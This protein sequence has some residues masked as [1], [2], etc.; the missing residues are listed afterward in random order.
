MKRWTCLAALLLVVSCK[1]EKNGSDYKVVVPKVETPSAPTERE[2]KTDAK[3][4]GDKIKKEAHEAAQSDA[5]KEIVHGAKEMG[6]G[7]KKGAGK[8]ATAAGNAL[9]KVGDKAQSDTPH[10]GT[11]TR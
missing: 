7:L 9:K 5:G 3:K 11:T 4:L 2:L 1:V 8:A 10:D 6:Q